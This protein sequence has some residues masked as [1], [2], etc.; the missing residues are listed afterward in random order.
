[1]IDGKYKG[2]AVLTR[3]KSTLL[4]AAGGAIGLIAGAAL[5]EALQA[6]SAVEKRE[7]KD[8]TV[9]SC[10]RKVCKQVLVWDELHRHETEMEVDDVMQQVRQS[11][12]KVRERYRNND[13][14]LSSLPEA[15]VKP[16]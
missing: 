15:K 10:L 16:K 12:K 2:V 5:R 7:K 14:Y 9:V 11:V 3:G 6:G 8:G 1:M 4:L 13:G